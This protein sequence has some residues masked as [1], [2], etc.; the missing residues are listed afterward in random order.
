MIYLLH[1][2]LIQ[3]ILE[4]QCLQDPCHQLHLLLMALINVW[5]YMGL[6][7]RNILSLATP[8][9]L[10][11]GNAGCDEP[12]PPVPALLIAHIIWASHPTLVILLII[13]SWM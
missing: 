4:D 12:Q 10:G 6:K 9:S 13:G 8:D 1:Q 7:G 5:T 3:Q 11:S 2:S